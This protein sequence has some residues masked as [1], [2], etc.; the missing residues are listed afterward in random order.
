MKLRIALFV[1]ARPEHGAASVWSS[2]FP[3]HKPLALLIVEMELLR[4]YRLGRARVRGFDGAEIFAT[5]ADDGDAP[6]PRAAG[7]VGLFTRR[8]TDAGMVQQAGRA[9]VESGRNRYHGV[10]RAPDLPWS[11]SSGLGMGRRTPSHRQI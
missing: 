8:L 2:D 7:G 5:A 11:T 1:L 10:R 6:A 3:Q 4:R 9:R